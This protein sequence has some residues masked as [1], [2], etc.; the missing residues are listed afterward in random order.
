MAFSKSERK[1]SG[2]YDTTECPHWESQDIKENGT[3][4]VLWPDGTITE[5]VPILVTLDQEQDH[6]S[7]DTHMIY[8]AEI[9]VTIH[10]AEAYVSIYDVEIDHWKPNKP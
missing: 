4:S 9:P 10:G 3:A 5:N 8:T 1:I 2:V 7:G 6:S